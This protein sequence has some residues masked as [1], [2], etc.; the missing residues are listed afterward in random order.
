[1]RK[2][3]AIALL[4]ASPPGAMADEDLVRFAPWF[5]ADP[6]GPTFQYTAPQGGLAANIPA[7]QM[8]SDRGL[9]RV[10]MS[11]KGIDPISGIDLDAIDGVLTIGD[12]PD[13]LLVLLGGAEMAAGVEPA[14]AA[15]DYEKR[16]INGVSVLGK[17]EDHAIDLAAARAPD[18]LGGGM[19]MSQRVALGDGYVAVARSWPGIEDAMTSIG[20][21]AGGTV[22]WQSVLDALAIERGEGHL[23]AA[24][25]WGGDTF[26][27][28]LLDPADLIG[29]DFDEAREAIEAA[30]DGPQLHFPP[31]VLAAFA[32]D[33]S[34]DSSHLRIALPYGNAANA[35]AAADYVAKH[36]IEWPRVPDH[37]TVALVEQG[38]TVVAVLTIDFPPTETEA[39][40]RLLQDWV[41]ATMRRKFTPL[42]YGVF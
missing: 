25:G 4:L 17:G 37:P 15:R 33:S 30:A 26:A 19:G 23:D 28:M 24:W 8:I 36:I 41:G 32:L 7:I 6:T 2:A 27:G 16:E 5:A 18:P 10:L 22:I 29:K 14:L 38:S 11:Q 12:P 21:E 9:Q 39:A 3:L 13:T 31:F 40:N 20:S 35:Q 42:Q 1:M 34:A